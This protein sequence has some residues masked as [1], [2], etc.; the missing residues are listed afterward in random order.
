MAYYWKMDLCLAI[1]SDFCREYYIILT[2]YMMFPGVAHEER[3][4]ALLPQMIKKLEF[5]LTTLKI[6]LATEKYKHYKE[7][8]LPKKS[9]DYNFYLSND[10]HDIFHG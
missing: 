3:V 8:L 5:L 1:G 9:M 2:F 6:F 10:I 7:G 4:F